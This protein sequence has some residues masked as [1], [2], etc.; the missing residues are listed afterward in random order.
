PWCLD[1]RQATGPDD[2][3][4]VAGPRS[5][6]ALPRRIPLPERLVRPPAVHVAGVLGEDR[7]DE[8]LHGIPS[9][10]RLQRPEVPSQAAVD[11]SQGCGRR[12]VAAPGPARDV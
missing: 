11:L 12:T 2:G 10:W 8:L 4:E 6:E 1:V 5:R 9:A 3:S 7:E